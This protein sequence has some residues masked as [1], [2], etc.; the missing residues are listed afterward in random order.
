MCSQGPGKGL[1]DTALRPAESGYLTRRLIDVSQ[2]GIITEEECGT[3][4]GMLITEED[5]KDMMLPDIRDRL[6]GRVLLDPIPGFEWIEG[7]E[8]V[9]DDMV[10]PSFTA[11]S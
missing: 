5:S 6:K 3:T 11:G 9:T 7:G 4:E 1:A 10:D 2:D 8:E